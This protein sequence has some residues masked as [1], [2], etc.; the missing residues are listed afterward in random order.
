MLMSKFCILISELEVSLWAHEIFCVCAHVWITPSY[1]QAWVTEMDWNSDWLRNN[2]Y[3][4][5]PD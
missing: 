3:P 2:E 5:W 4:Q 1:S